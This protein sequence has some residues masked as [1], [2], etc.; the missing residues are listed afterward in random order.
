MLDYVSPVP[1]LWWLSEWWEV[2]ISQN[3]ADVKASGL[4]P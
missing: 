3:G 4:W 1:L 2:D